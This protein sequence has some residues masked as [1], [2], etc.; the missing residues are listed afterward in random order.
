MSYVF[1]FTGS[2]FTFKYLIHFK[3]VIVCGVREGSSFSLFHAAVQFSQYHFLKRLFCCIFLTSCWKLINHMYMSLFLGSL[4]CSM[5]ICICFYTQ[6][7]CFFWLWAQLENLFRKL[8][9]AWTG[10]SSTHPGKGA[11][12]QPH[13]LWLLTPS[14]Q[15]GWEEP[16]SYAARGTQANTRECRANGL[17]SKAS[18]PLWPGSLGHRSS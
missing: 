16:G 5:D 15:K 3:L 4:F 14:C 13:W 6:Y 9:V 1:F 12:T 2:D 7:I 10:F 11:E 17:Q 18:G 8:R